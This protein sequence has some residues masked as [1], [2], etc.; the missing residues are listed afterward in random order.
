MTRKTE[1]Y[2]QEDI[3]KEEFNH[4]YP[5]KVENLEENNQILNQDTIIRNNSQNHKNKTEI[6]KNDLETPKN[7]KENE[8]IIKILQKVNSKKHFL[9]IFKF[10]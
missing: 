6:I 3:K 4:I 8:C 1:E 10:F 2:S 9:Y 5:E 7:S